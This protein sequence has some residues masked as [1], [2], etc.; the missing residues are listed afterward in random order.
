MNTRI[1]R[2]EQVAAEVAGLLEAFE[3]WDRAQFLRPAQ[4]EWQTFT[5]QL[6]RLNN[7]VLD[8]PSEGAYN[9]A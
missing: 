7:K 1:D 3:L 8:F 6:V 5:R 2:G 9:G 4:A